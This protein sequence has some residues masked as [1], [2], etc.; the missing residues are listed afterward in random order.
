MEDKLDFFIISI[1]IVFVGKHAQDFLTP[2]VPHF[3]YI[4][5]SLINQS[6]F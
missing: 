2:E 6:Y 3:K 1:F 4:S 5:C